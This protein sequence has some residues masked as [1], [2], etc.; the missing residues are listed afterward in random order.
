MSQ[1]RPIVPQKTAYTAAGTGAMLCGEAL[2]CLR[3]GSFDGVPDVFGPV[4]V[5]DR[6]RPR[7]APRRL[8]GQ[9]VRETA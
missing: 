7:A 8:D 5:T 9:R 3:G 4:G 1:N 6:N 2:L